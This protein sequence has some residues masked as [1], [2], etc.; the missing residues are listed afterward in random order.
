[1]KRLHG[2]FDAPV[3]RVEFT[4]VLFSQIDLTDRPVRDRRPDDDGLR[5]RRRINAGTAQVAITLSEFKFAPASIQVKPGA[6]RFVLKNSGVIGHT[7]VIE[8]LKKGTKEIAPGGEAVMEVNAKP[9]TY[10]AICD[11]PGHKEAG[12]TMTVVVK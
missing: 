12:M 2:K 3:R 1:M 9:G 6:V 10:E 7:F 4:D 11:I 8:G 5:L